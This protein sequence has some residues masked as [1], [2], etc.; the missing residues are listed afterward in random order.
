[1][2]F[3]FLFPLTPLVSAPPP[4]RPYVG[5]AYYKTKGKYV[6]YITCSGKQLH[7][8]KGGDERGYRD[9]GDG[10]G[11][12]GGGIKLPPPSFPAVLLSRAHSL[13][14]FLSFSFM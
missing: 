1:L 8:G 14:L 3:G 5:V 13:S 11:G 2:T 6:A 10:G 9:S 12:G 4:T 7:I